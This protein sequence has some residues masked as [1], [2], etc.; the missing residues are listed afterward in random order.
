MC[1]AIC[2]E[3][4]DGGKDVA[5]LVSQRQHGSSAIPIDPGIRHLVCVGD[6]VAVAIRPRSHAADPFAGKGSA[7]RLDRRSPIL[8]LFLDAGIGDTV[9]IAGLC[10]HGA[11]CPV[12]IARLA[13]V[14]DTV[15]WHRNPG[16]ALVGRA[17]LEIVRKWSHADFHVL[18]CHDRIHQVGGG[19]LEGIDLSIGIHRG[20]RI[21]RENHL[22][23]AVAA[24]LDLRHGAHR[25]RIDAGQCHET[26]FHGSLH[27]DSE[28]AGRLVVLDL[29]DRQVRQIIM[30]GVCLN[31]AIGDGNKLRVGG[32]WRAAACKCCCVGGT[33]HDGLHVISSDYVDRR[34]DNQND[35]QERQSEGHRDVP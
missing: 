10:L 2:P 24:P 13:P 32:G 19:R 9:I 27:F 26:C 18:R 25:D 6:R 30:D 35:R 29:P 17:N 3:R 21:E 22:E 11:A 12:W 28:G 33:L 31:V 5:L 15:W 16:F 1:V 34:P 14:V 8:A 4:V 23:R 7:V 20:R